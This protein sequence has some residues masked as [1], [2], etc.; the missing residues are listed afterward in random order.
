LRFFEVGGTLLSLPLVLRTRQQ[1]EEACRH[2]VSQHP[3]DILESFDTG[4]QRSS[5]MFIIY[6]F[7]ICSS[8]R[9]AAPCYHWMCHFYLQQEPL[10]LSIFH[11]RWL[12]DGPPFLQKRWVM[13]IPTSTENPEVLESPAESLSF[14]RYAG[15]KFVNGMSPDRHI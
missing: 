10:P 2:Q 14:N 15:D 1:W 6:S 12:L 13:T 4:V 11:P 3:R 7:L 9:T 5:S 8:G